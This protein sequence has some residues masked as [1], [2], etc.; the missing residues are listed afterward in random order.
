MSYCYKPLK[1]RTFLKSSLLAS[2]CNMNKTKCFLNSCSQNLLNCF[3]KKKIVKIQPWAYTWNIKYQPK[4]L[5]FDK[6]SKCG[7]IIGNIWQTSYYA[8]LTPPIKNISL[9]VAKSFIQTSICRCSH[10]FLVCNSSVILTF[11]K[12]LSTTRQH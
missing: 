4:W 8:L 5:K 11:S 12:L 1:N 9:C 3:N 10:Y 2:F 6:V 7:F